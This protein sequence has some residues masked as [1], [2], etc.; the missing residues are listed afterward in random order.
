MM[1]FAQ[2]SDMFK[3]FKIIFSYILLYGIK[4][5]NLLTNKN[6]ILLTNY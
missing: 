3:K 2:W 4:F 5:N 6:E 1:I